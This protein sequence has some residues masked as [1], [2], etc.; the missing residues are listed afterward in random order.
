LWRLLRMF[1]DVP[2]TIEP[3]CRSGA[4][5]YQPAEVVDRLKSVLKKIHGQSGEKMQ[6][7]E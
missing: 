1:I 6:P 2:H 3:Q 7:Q 4:N 5:P